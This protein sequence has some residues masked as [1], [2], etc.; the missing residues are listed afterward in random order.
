M[1]A[2]L[3]QTR[4]QATAVSKAVPPPTRGWN[5]VTAL[6]QMKEDDAVRL[7]NLFPKFTSVHGRGGSSVHC[8]T[9]EADYVDMLAELDIGSS[10]KFI[11]GVNGKIIDVTTA[12]PSTLA[13]GYSVDRWNTVTFKDRVFGMNGT[14]TPF[15]Y[16]GSTVTD[17]TFTGP[18]LTNL[19]SGAHFNERIY[20]IEQNTS[21]Y[22]YGGVGSVAGALTEVDLNTI[23][24][25]GGTLQTIGTVS[26]DGGAGIDDLICF[27]FSS[28]EVIVYKGSYPGGADWAKVGNYWIGAPIGRK[29][30]IKKGGDLWCITRDGYVPLMRVMLEGRGDTS[31]WFSH[32]ILPA[33]SAALGN[34]GSNTGWEAVFYP[35][36]EKALFNVPVSSTTFHQHVVNVN[37]GAWCK[38]EDWNANCWSLF[39]DDLY[40]G[41]ADGY[42]MKA[43]TGTADYPAGVETA[44]KMD[45]QTAWNYFGSRG[46]QKQFT[47]SRP[48]FASTATLNLQIGMGVDFNDPVPSYAASTVTSS[49]PVWDETIWDMGIWAGGEVPSRVWQSNTGIGYCASMRVRAE[50]TD[51]SVIWRSTNYMFKKGGFI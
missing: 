12:T 15:V 26:R 3:R 38:F 6:D 22:H 45:G 1:L 44:I 9:G 49:G 16:D 40:F 43:D 5:A 50:V 29:G 25:G 36:G 34:Y 31:K 21:K 24:Q 7:V 10:R 47:F 37:T 17:Q 8:S 18:T 4:Q 20:L 23:T 13:T 35:S 46:N 32:N 41:T 33:V 28:G 30:I 11:A 2:P 27:F 39:N 48:I 42:V 14:D 19:I 51:Q